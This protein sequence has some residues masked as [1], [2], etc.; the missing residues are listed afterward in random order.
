MVMPVNHF[1]HTTAVIFAQTEASKRE[2]QAPMKSLQD[3]R[4]DQIGDRCEKLLLDFYG[5]SLYVMLF[6]L[7]GLACKWVYELETCKDVWFPE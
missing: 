2:Q 4:I 7:I 6:A 1:S 5:L 3:E